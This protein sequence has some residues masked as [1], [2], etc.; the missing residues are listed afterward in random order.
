M[1]VCLGLVCSGGKQILLAADTRASYGSV[2]SNDQTAKLF[3]LPAKYCGAVAG[4]LSQCEDVISE[5]YHQ[6]ARLS[7]A[8]IARE[9]VRKCILDSYDQIY[10]TLADQALRNDPRITLK[11][12]VYDQNIAP[13]VRQDAKEVLQSDVDLIVSG[14]YREQPV[15]L[16]AEGGTS[17]K[18][19]SEIT[20]GN[21]AIGAGAIAALNWL[22][23]RKQNI[24][25]GLAHSLFHLTEAKQFAEVDTS[26]GPFRQMLLVWSGGFKP[27]EGG[28]DL[29]QGWWNKYG[30]PLRARAK[31]S[32]HI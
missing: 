17:V 22:N 8:E 26:V 23:Y 31:I 12:Y 27:L 25:L 4:T 11:Q 6:M 13:S 16:I 7:D 5:L 3:D 18:I 29:M 21:A 10:S 2:T 32:S 15:Q 9:Q 28:D 14:F 30:L 24:R 19:R 20:P 1:T